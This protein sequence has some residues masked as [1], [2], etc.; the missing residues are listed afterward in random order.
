MSGGLFLVSD[1]GGTNA[2][3]ALARVA[4]SEIAVDAP[5][6][7]HTADYA[8]LDAALAAFLDLKG[9]PHLDAVAVCAAG[10]V[11]GE[12]AAAHVHMTNCPWEVSVRALADATG[13]SRPVL[14][15]DFAALARAVPALKP[16]E[17]HAVGVGKADANAPIG[18]LGAGT[19]LGVAALVPAAG[20]YI[21][22]PGEGGHVDLAPT[23]AREIEVLTHLMKVHGRVSVERVLSGPGLVALHS[24]LAAIEG[25]S[26]EGRLTGADISQ[27]AQAKT[28]ALAAEAVS[29]FCGWLGSVAG[30]LALTLG[31]KG[32]I[33]IGG[34]IVP[35]WIANERGLFDEAL[36]RRRFEAKGRF[37]SYLAAIPVNVIMRGDA[38]LLGL[39]HAARDAT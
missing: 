30:N 18:L 34:G 6:I 21:A 26:V 1:I 7:F 22:V 14:V 17:L 15:N 28:S 3:F 5:T 33:F 8:S 23:N 36:F 11:E 24:A 4:G 35:G 9:H 16:H 10:P 29:M 31:A 32:G 38:A 19:G 25:V 37:E 12:G 27:R 20:R 39:A 2:R 13:V